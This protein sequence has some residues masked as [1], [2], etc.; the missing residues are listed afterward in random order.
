M[1]KRVLIVGD[2]HSGSKVSPVCNDPQTSEDSNGAFCRPT[3]IQEYLNTEWYNMI[4]NVGKIDILVGNGDLIEGANVKE[5]GAGCWTT[6]LDDQAYCAASLLSDIKYDK[7]MITSG[8]PYHTKNNPI[9]DKMVAGKL[10]RSTFGNE[11]SLDVNGC[12]I[13]V[14]HNTG[15]SKG[16]N[17]MKVAS[18]SRELMFAELNSDAFPKYKMVIKSHLHTYVSIDFGSYIGILCPGWKGRDKYSKMS[19]TPLSFV[20]WIGYIIIDVENDGTFTWDKW[21]R[22]LS[23]RYNMD[24]CKV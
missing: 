8:S 14:N 2:L 6:D 12:L 3:P 11:A 9:G 18:L 24:T 21:V 7:I 1:S 16:S 15:G 13:Y 23:S 19:S 20:P 4:D 5:E 10:R 17:H 22:K